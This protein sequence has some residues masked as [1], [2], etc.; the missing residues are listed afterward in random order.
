MATNEAN[1]CI[2]DRSTIMAPCVNIPEDVKVQSGSSLSRTKTAYVNNSRQ[3]KN[4]AVVGFHDHGALVDD[5]KKRVRCN[6][7][8]KEIDSY[9]LLKYHL[10]GMHES[11]VPCVKVPEDVKLQMRNSLPRTTI[12]H[13]NNSGQGKNAAIVGSQDHGSFVDG[14]KKRCLVLKSQRILSYI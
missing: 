11:V 8:G 10:G 13:V 5:V 2:L 14:V 3:G 12:T 4:D 6:Y 1:V 7:C 9:Y